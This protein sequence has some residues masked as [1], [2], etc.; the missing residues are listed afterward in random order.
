[1][2]TSVAL[3]RMIRLFICAN[4]RIPPLPYKLGDGRSGR[5]FVCQSYPTSCFQGSRGELSR[6]FFARPRWMW[7]FPPK[8]IVISN[9]IAKSGVDMFSGVSFG[10]RPPFHPDEFASVN[11]V[12]HFCVS[13][14]KSS[15]LHY[16]S[17]WCQTC[18]PILF[19]NFL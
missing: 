19:S 18:R 3:P 9:L 8:S 2:L 17:A 4:C 12:A 13:W 15:R 14:L 16:F 6:I 7:Q 1:M 5:E 10:K 11:S